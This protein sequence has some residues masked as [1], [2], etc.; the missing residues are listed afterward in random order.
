MWDCLLVDCRIATMVPA[1]GNPLGIVE[2]GAVAIQDGRI[3]RVGK[4]T[5]LAG[6]RAKEV[7]ALGGAWLLRERG[8]RGAS[9][10]GTLEAADPL[11]AAVPALV[12]LAAGLVAVR[13]FPLPM[14]LLAWL[15][16]GRRGL[17]PVLAM[18][19]ATSGVG[20]GPIL[21]VLLAGGVALVGLS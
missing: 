1:P 5:E 2:N 10:A 8:V 15:A 9:S 18:R 20:V 21:V 11:I 7:V 12:G 6:F 19:R 14:R 17:V 4:R 16:R 3:L 13:L